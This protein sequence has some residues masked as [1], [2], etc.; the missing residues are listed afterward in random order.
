MKGLVESWISKAADGARCLEEAMDL[1]GPVEL[2]FGGA[3]RSTQVPSGECRLQTVWW[4]D[5]LR[6]FRWAPCRS[7]ATQ[8]PH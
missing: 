6:S 5:A 2:F 3:A 8:E 4:A 7:D 1:F